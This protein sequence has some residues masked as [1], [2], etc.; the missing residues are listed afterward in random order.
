MS[1]S[2][3]PLRPFLRLTQLGAQPAARRY[4]DDNVDPL[5]TVDPL[6][7]PFGSVSLDDSI[8][9]T[10]NAG[11]GRIAQ[12]FAAA[13]AA[14]ADARRAPSPPAREARRSG[15]CSRPRSIAQLLFP[16]SS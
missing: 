7:D 9:S 10:K 3:P 2:L 6:V 14:L 11:D 8:H 1:T 5:V 4:R 13:P 15:T 16:H 12:L